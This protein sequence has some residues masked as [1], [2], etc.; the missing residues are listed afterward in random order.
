MP[1]M[2]EIAFGL[3]A[4]SFVLVVVLFIRQQLLISK[5]KKFMKGLGETDVEQ[6]MQQYAADLLALR[7]YVENKTDVRVQVLEK[8][9]KTSLR[10]TGM[11][12]YNAFEHMGNM[13][14]F[15]VAMLDDDKNGVVLTGI[16]SRDSSYV[17]AK[18]ITNGQSDKELS[19]EEKEVLGKAMANI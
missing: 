8:K 13:M 7:T 3:G 11:M 4:V 17:Y 2:L 1:Y 14:S 18:L 12:C 9:M 16:Y 15:S 5:Y 6:V 19:K 10:N